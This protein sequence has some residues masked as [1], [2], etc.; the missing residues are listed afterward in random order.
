[1]TSTH[2]NPI[3][4]VL[5][6]LL[7]LLLGTV[8]TYQAQ[9]T[10]VADQTRA[11]S[12]RAYVGDVGCNVNTNTPI[13]VTSS[14][15]TLEQHGISRAESSAHEA[16]H[17][18]QLADDCMT[19]LAHWYYNPLQRLDTEAEAECAGF[20]TYS[21]PAKRVGRKHEMI[22]AL[23]MLYAGQVD[24]GA[25]YDAFDRWCTTTDLATVR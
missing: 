13:P 10:P 8:C 25:V 6:V 3:I 23:M 11:I 4:R 15:A 18:R 14:D 19:T 2:R 7:V 16:T 22:R 17:L 20:R 12:S 24:P 1:M 9:A 5:I 21:D